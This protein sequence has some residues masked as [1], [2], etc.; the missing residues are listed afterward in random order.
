[1]SSLL[2]HP[3][4][5]LDCTWG[6][7]SVKDTG[8]STVP[9]GCYCSTVLY[10]KVQ[11]ESKTTIIS[12]VADL[13]QYHTICCDETANISYVKMTYRYVRLA[14]VSLHWA[15][16]WNQGFTLFFSNRLKDGWKDGANKQLFYSCTQ[17]IQGK[18]LRS[19]FEVVF[20]SVIYLFGCDYAAAAKQFH[21]RTLDPLWL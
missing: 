18:S 15:H 12:N 8:H 5:P 1:M 16:G 17:A 19:F 13:M 21:R 9:W 3:P 20:W 7:Y 4:L 10:Q 2:I 11:W 6:P 14:E